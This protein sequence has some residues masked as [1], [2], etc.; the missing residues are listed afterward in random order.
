MRPLPRALKAARI[1]LFFYAAVVAL[2]VVGGLI[3]SHLSP[4]ILAVLTW[5]AIPGIIA[6]TLALRIPQG[7][8]L[9]LI[10]SVV[11]MS[12]LILGAL[13]RIGFGDPQGLINLVFPTA[14]L[15]LMLRRSSRNHLSS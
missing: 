6:L 15:V 8:R 11:F 4:E 12:L 9:L 5:V 3:I 10:I 2:Q 1:L 13:G 7:G 14:V